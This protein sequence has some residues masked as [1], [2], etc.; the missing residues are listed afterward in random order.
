MAGSRTETRDASSY[1]FRVVGMR[2]APLR[3]FYHRLLRWRWPATLGTIALGYLAANAL[4]AAAFAVCGGVSNSR[5]GSFADAFY[6]SVQTMGT[7]GYGTMTPTTPVAH[8][9][10]VL[11]SITG[12]I[13]T[14]LSTGL[15]FAKFSLPT[16]RVAFSRNIVIHAMNGVPNLTF[17]IGNSRSNRLVDVE[18][19]CIM[20]RTE[21]LDEGGV[22]YRAIDLPPSRTRALSL[23]RSWN[24]MHP[25]DES[26]PLA[27]ATP[28]SV[29]AD[30]IEVHVL[31][32][33]MDDTTM[34]RVHASHVYEGS[35]ILWNRRH[36][37]VLLETEDG[38]MLLDLT[39]FSDTLPVEE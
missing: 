21:Q 18:I 14:A 8:L 23:S 9:L 7:I 28:E 11:E 6:F 10:V 39:R 4:F 31:V 1:R 13:I 26:S 35:D 2:W 17:R 20:Y 32:A 19:Q 3:D 16:A 36:A 5:P 38:D 37:D 30:E 34:Q 33:G 15:V 29:E 24:V 25:I 22:F 27:G 12:L